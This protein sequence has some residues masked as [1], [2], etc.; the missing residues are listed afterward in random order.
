MVRCFDWGP[1][2]GMAKAP[3]PT[4]WLTVRV[5]VV[6]VT[7]EAEGTVESG[8]FPVCVYRT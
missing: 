7:P 6:V 4:F 3:L 2:K 5:A 1:R 8:S